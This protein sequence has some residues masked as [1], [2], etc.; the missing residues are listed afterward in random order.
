MR[1]E[2]VESLPVPDEVALPVVDDAGVDRA[3]RSF[4]AAI[5]SDNSL[6]RCEARGARLASGSLVGTSGVDTSGA[7]LCSGDFV[8]RFRGENL[9]SS[10]RLHFSLVEKLV[11]LLKEAGSADSLAAR[12][13]L[14]SDSGGETKAS[15]FALRLRLEARGN[16]SEQAGLRWGL[17]VAHVQQALLFTSRYL[18]QQMAQSAD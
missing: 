7:E 6:F 9:G 2:V 8:L 15:G 12:I 17:G 1:V 13:C 3:L 10:R 16:S 18:R 4:F 5:E 11:E 14:T